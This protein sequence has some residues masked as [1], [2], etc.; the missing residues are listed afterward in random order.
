[1]NTGALPEGTFESEL[2]GHVKGA[3]T[4]ARMDRIGRFELANGETLFLDEIANIPVRQQA[5]LLRVLETGEIERVGSSKTKKVD[6]EEH[7]ALHL[8]AAQAQGK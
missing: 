5:K 1:V 8:S 2:F 7:Y 6:D 4:D 3:F